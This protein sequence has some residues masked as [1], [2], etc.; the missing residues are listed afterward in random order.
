MG[1]IFL[2]LFVGLCISCTAPKDQKESGLFTMHCSGCHKAPEINDLPRE[3]WASRIL[4][5]MAAR[6]G[7][8]TGGF[9]P[10]QGLSFS[11]MD[12]VIK[13]GIFPEKPAISKEDWE[14]L[15]GYILAIAPDSLS[16][17]AA[18]GPT[19]E[20]QMF[21]T[22]PVSLDSNGRSTITYLNFNPERK[23]LNAGDFSGNL[24]EYNI[25]DKKMGSMGRFGSAVVAYSI[26]NDTSY[27]TT[28]GNLRPSEIPGGRIFTGPG[29]R[30]VPLPE[31]FHRPVHTLVNDLNN[32]GRMELVVSEFGDLTG[33]LSLLTRG[34]DDTYKKQVLLNLPGTIRVIAE[35]MNNDGKTDLVAMTAQ[36]DEGITI[37][38]QG[39]DLK[40]EADKA[41]RFSPVYGSSWFELF[42][43]DDDGDKDIV[44]VHGDNADKSFV[45]KPYHGL[46]IHINQGSNIFQESFFFPFNG[47]TRVVARDFD[48]DGDVDFGLLSTF[49]DYRYKKGASFVYLENRDSGK[50]EFIPYSSAELN[51]GRWFLMDTGDMDDDG[52]EDIVL[53]AFSLSF[54]PV[55]P[56]L[57][58]LWKEKDVDIM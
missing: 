14:L 24:L 2:G 47:A 31:T 22:R 52:D 13:T 5:D 39:E 49:P 33:Q 43:Y 46:R 30:A 56:H 4:P 28:I 32:N 17:A 26:V 41:I 36:G 19:G 35:D 55:P 42:D 44:T 6:M 53:S 29:N 7:I 25:Q 8:R 18:R 15:K 57:E 38:Y 20:M 11:E 37:L 54:T 3:I 9:D 50:F 23:K 48:Q 58:K 27:V 12:A 10:Y 21:S 51:N 1:R 34:V 40:F 45:H 16:A